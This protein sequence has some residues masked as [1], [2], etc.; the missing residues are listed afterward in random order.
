M[1][2][3]PLVTRLVST[4]NA[5][6]DEEKRATSVAELACYLA[7]TGEFEEAD[8]LRVE[9]RRDF[10]DARSPPVSILIMCIESLLLY[11]R[12]LSENARDR[13]LR[14]NLLSMAFHENRLYTLTAAWLAHIDFNQNRFDTM[15][16]HLV[17]CARFVHA[18][19]GNA[20]CR[21][22]LVLGDAFLF[23]GD[24]AASRDWYE[25]ARRMATALGDHAAI[26]AMTYNRAALRVSRARFA[27]LSEPVTAEEVSLIST[28]VNSAINYQA[29]A[30]LKSLDHLLGTARAG[31]LMLRRAYGQA[32]AEIIKL[33][34][35]PELV[36]DSNQRKLLQADLALANAASSGATPDVTGWLDDAFELA[37]GMTADDRAL[38]LSTAS[39]VA[40]LLGNHQAEEYY[41][42][43]AREAMEEHGTAMGDLR[44]SIAKFAQGAFPTNGSN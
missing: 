21:A 10:G 29:A 27:S 14:A 2:T 12:D 1:V 40:S 20:E 34:S 11:Y 37:M 16:E 13:M 33:L 30:R 24:V 17:T 5:C 19:D 22:S 31:V 9:L 28:E 35:S 36:S 25:R 32:K 43:L 42:V 23:A 38:V 8:K 26:G 44:Q 39:S 18:D 6:G 7:R 15:A 3:S 41:R 4:I